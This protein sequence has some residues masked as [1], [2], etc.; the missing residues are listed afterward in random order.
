MINTQDYFRTLLL[1][2]VGQAFTAAGYTLDDRPLQWSGGLF[3]FA[4]RVNAGLITAIEFQ[5][6]IYHDSEWSNGAVSRFRVNLTRSDGIRR[7]LSALVVEDFQVAILPSGS[8]WWTYASVEQLGR[9]LGEAG[10]LAIGYGMP[11]LA[12]TLTPPAG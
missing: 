10:S 4:H 9:A 6:L 8:H 1:T 3:R 2:V 5:N 11:W 7:D 12:G